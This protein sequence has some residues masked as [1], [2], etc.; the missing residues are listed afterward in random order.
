MATNRIIQDHV[1]SLKDTFL[2]C[3][4]HCPEQSMLQFMFCRILYVGLLLLLLALGWLT[5]EYKCSRNRPLPIYSLVS[6]ATLYHV[7]KQ[8][9][10]GPKYQTKWW[11]FFLH[12]IVSLWYLM[13]QVKSKCIHKAHLK[14]THVDQGDDFNSSIR[15]K[16]KQNK[17]GCASLHKILPLVPEG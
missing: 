7:N 1:L 10:S 6:S 15:H 14:T 16:T 4:S 11:L 17:N 12:A 5:T 2:K 13:C 3:L 9:G 8:H